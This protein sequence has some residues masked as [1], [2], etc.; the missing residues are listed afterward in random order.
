MRTK[1]VEA[2]TCEKC[3]EGNV[4]VDDE[5]KDK[6]FVKHKIEKL[7]VWYKHLHHEEPIERYNFVEK[8]AVK[9]HDV[10]NETFS[11]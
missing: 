4:I 6:N 5:A 11:F 1:Q 2:G 3:H 8:K 10:V 7:G 9:G